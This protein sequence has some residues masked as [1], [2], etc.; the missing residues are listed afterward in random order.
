VTPDEY[1]DEVLRSDWYVCVN[2]EIGGYEIRTEPGPSSRNQ[3]IQVADFISQDIA[4]Y[5]VGL[6][7]RDLGWE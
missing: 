7:D 1:R 6:R 4:E 2:D 3:G 5:I